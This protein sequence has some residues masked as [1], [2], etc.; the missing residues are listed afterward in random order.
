MA[1]SCYLQEVMSFLWI[2]CISLHLYMVMD[3]R[4]HHAQNWNEEE[5]A[6]Y[7][8]CILFSSSVTCQP[9]YTLVRC[10]M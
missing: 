8:E 9:V 2:I 6:L 10:S 4:L 5:G 1:D 7:F 3:A